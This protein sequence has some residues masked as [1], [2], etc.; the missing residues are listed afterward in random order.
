M[1]DETRSQLRDKADAQT[2]GVADGLGRLADELRA[3]ANGHPDQAATVRRYVDQAGSAM[4]DVAGQLRN[5]DFAGIVDDLQRFA[6]RRPGAFLATSAAVGFIAGRLVRSARDDA[7]EADDVDTST[8][9]TGNGASLAPQQLP[10]ERPA[11]AGEG[12]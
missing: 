5:K 9:P 2:A 11:P 12:S 6:R 8:S 1:V 4:A 10:S 3:L 7:G